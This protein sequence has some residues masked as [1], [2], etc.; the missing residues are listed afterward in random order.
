MAL[1]PV[2]AGRVRGHFRSQSDLS[3]QRLAL[4]RIAAALALNLPNDPSPVAL[5]LMKT[6]EHDTLS[7]WER[8]LLEIR[9]VVK[10]KLLARQQSPRHV[11]QCS[12]PRVRNP[13][14]LRALG[15]AKRIQ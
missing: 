9:L 6:P 5:G 7:P 10:D 8:A 11:G 12:A 1:S 2:V 4:V 13:L 3:H 15:L 14:H